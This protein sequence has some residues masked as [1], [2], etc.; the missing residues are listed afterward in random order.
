MSRLAYTTRPSYG[1]GWIR[2]LYVAAVAVLIGASVLAFVRGIGGVTKSAAGT[3]PGSMEERVLADAYEAVKQDPNNATARWQLSIALS[4]LGDHERARTEAEAAV[5]LDR[6]SV[7]AFYAL[8]LAYRGDEDLKKAEKALAKAA[9]T[10]GALGEVYREVYYDLGQVRIE[11]GDDKG[12]VEAYQAALG[13]GP[14]AT[15]IVLALADAYLETGD[16]D[17]AKTEYLAVLGYDPD[18]EVAAKALKSL[19]V[20]DTEI[21]DARTPIAHETSAR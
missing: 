19:G 18:N 11:L 20:S 10:P 9:A 4:T 2:L 16:K 3:A 12:A 15:Y 1:T 17:K 7:E 5:K 6:N 21:A 8:G 13:N 14:E